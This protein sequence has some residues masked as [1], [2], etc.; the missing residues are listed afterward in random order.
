MSCINAPGLQEQSQQCMHVVILD[1]CYVPLRV[2][3][4]Q[5]S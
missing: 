5:A 2:C 3:F 4:V 1:H